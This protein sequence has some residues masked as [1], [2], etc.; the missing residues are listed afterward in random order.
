[1]GWWERQYESVDGR[2]LLHPGP[3]MTWRMLKEA[4]KGIAGFVTHY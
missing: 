3:S 2:L 4:M 1:M